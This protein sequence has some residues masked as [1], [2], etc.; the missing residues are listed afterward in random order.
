MRLYFLWGMLFCDRV[1][2][3]C[4][5]LWAADVMFC[6]WG[7]E[8][9]VECYTQNFRCFVQW[10]GGSTE[11]HLWVKGGLMPVCGY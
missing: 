1:L 8:V 10:N 11:E 9:C 5:F 6:I 2:M 4:I 3:K 7:G